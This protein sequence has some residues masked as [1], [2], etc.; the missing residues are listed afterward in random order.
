MVR[1]RLVPKLKETEGAAW[2]GFLRAHALITRRMDADLRAE[3]DLTLSEF[4]ILLH[5]AGAG[6]QKRMAQIAHEAIL[7]GGGVTRIVARLER[8]GFIERRACPKDG[9]G[10][11]AALTEPGWAKQRAAHRVHLNGIRRLFLSAG[12]PR[13]LKAVARV[14]TKAIDRAR[15]ES[16]APGVAGDGKAT[17][18]EAAPPPHPATRR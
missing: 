14:F 9:R 4:E 2:G 15:A 16:G 7:T 12:S 13:D 3:S 1:P 11:F 10:V 5:L 17:E 18:K 8:L 6:G